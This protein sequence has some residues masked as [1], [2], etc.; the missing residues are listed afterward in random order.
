M[1]E[2]FFHFHFFLPPDDGRVDVKVGAEETVLY[3]DMEKFCRV[4]E[5][6]IERS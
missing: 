3:Q 5:N 1:K 6:K 2:Y 4:W